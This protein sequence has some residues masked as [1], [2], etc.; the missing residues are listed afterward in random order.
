MYDRYKLKR[1]SRKIYKVL[2]LFLL[3]SYV[4]Y[5]GYRHR[6]YILFWKYTYNKLVQKIDSAESS[7]DIE[8]KRKNLID[9]TKVCNNYKDENSFSSEAYFLSGRVNFL[10][11]ETM[12]NE[13]FSRLIINDN[14]HKIDER[15]RSQFYQ[16]I[17]DIKKGIALSRDD[18]VSQFYLI[19]AKA[20]FYLDYCDVKDI[21]KLICKMPID[22]LPNSVEDIRFY[23][24]LCILN[25]EADRGIDIIKEYGKISDE[26]DGMLFLATANRIAGR[27]TLAILEYKRV[28]DRTSDSKIIKLVHVNL[29]KIYYN[30]LLFKESLYHFNQA[31]N[32]DERDNLLKIWI[33]KNY[34]ALGYKMRAKAIWSEVLATDNS[35]REVRKLLG[36]M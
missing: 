22:D 16:V 33:G 36:L 34:S 7:S 19:L 18:R 1:R 25:N 20:M 17:K 28:L 24:I 32:I 30:R 11:G 8:S 4:A 3:I 5:L 6:N 14:L 2:F 35:N 9:L 27:Y 12:V 29:G 31:L 21:Y 13:T 10:L 15:A 23:G 26:I